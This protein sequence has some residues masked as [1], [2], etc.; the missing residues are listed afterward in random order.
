MGSNQR[1]NSPSLCI[2][3][4]IAAIAHQRNAMTF[5]QY[6]Q[7]GGRYSAKATPTTSPASRRHW[8]FAA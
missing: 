4:D 6:R 2:L 3:K 8:N 5:S 1:E 7:S